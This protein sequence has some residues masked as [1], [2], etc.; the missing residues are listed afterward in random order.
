MRAL[1]ALLL[2][3]N[4]AAAAESVRLAS[5]GRALL[6]IVIGEKASPSTKA[7]AAELAGFLT[8]ICG[9][10]FVVEPGDGSRGIVLGTAPDFAKLPFSPAFGAGPFERED[11]VLRSAKDGVW[12]VGASELGAEH[13][14][15][16]FLHRL[17]HRQFFPG[18]TW[19]VVP[20]TRDLAIDVDA[21]E[22]PSFHARRI[23]YNWGMWG[24]NN[25]PYRQWCA[26]NR[27]VQGFQLRFSAATTAPRPL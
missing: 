8:K 15:W 20:E 24:Y 27:A 2:L 18:E 16:D 13:A 17:G 14:S 5:E 23:W 7:S 9:A 26:R 4:V 25:E 11:Y 12:L 19:E 10:T 3:F 1:I 22:S 21:K 6:P